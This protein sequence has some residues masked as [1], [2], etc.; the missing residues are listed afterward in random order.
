[1]ADKIQQLPLDLDLDRD[2]IDWIASKPRNRRNETLRRAI[3]DYM[4]RERGEVV[5]PPVVVVPDEKPPEK[6]R[7]PSMRLLG[8]S[9][10]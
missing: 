9:Q 8:L 4:A 2:I 7:E 5:S 10:R 1:M 3:R 6:R